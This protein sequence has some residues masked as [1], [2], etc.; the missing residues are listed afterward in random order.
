MLPS[1][2]NKNIPCYYVSVAF[3]S[4]KAVLRGKTDGNYVFIRCLLAR[5]VWFSDVRIQTDFRT[6]LQTNGSL[7]QLSVHQTRTEIMSTY[8]YL[9]HVSY[10]P[11]PWP[12]VCWDRGFESPPWE[13][14]FVCCVVCCQVEVSGTSWSLVQ[15]SRIPTVMRRCVWSRNL[16]NEE[17]MARDRPQRHTRKERPYNPLISQMDQMVV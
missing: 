1:L 9:T 10:N 11:M 8:S 13:W 2:L 17:A 14:M 15:M 7:F 3:S 6:S 12:L 5:F 16:K 4:T